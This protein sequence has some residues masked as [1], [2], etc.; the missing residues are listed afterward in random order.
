MSLTPSEQIISIN[1]F[2]YKKIKRMY[3][4]IEYED[5]S[6]YKIIDPF[7]NIPMLPYPPITEDPV[8][9][10]NT[11]FVPSIGNLPQIP[12]PELPE[13]TMQRTKEP[14]QPT[15]KMIQVPNLEQLIFEAESSIESEHEKCNALT[16]KPDPTLENATRF[17]KCKFRCIKAT[18]FCARHTNAIRGVFTVKWLKTDLAYRK[19]RME[20]QNNVNEKKRKL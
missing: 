11:Q 15:L 14:E 19:K 3:L 18:E 10:Q 7:F 1:H 6:E 13:P 8:M 2:P 12:L 9:S 4:T 20:K 16:L 5:E 17:Y